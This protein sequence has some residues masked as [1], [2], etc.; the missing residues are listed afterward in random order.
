MPD[1]EGAKSHAVFLRTAISPATG[2]PHNW[3]KF[4]QRCFFLEKAR[5]TWA[6]A[7]QFCKTIGGNL[8]SIH[9]AEEYNHLQQMTSEPTWIGGSA[10]QEETNWFWT[11]GTT[12]DF[13]FWCPAQPDN[14]KEQC[15]LQ[16]NTGVGQCWDDVGCSSMQQSICVMSL[17]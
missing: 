6:N 2:C 8:A 1:I 14:T 11:D 13:T 16:M 9:S 17:I 4:G 15:C 10:C 5:R 7:Q 12:L 3:S